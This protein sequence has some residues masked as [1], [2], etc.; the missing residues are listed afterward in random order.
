MILDFSITNPIPSNTKGEKWEQ[1][2]LAF[3]SS[4]LDGSKSIEV[5]TSGSTGNPKKIT[6]NKE[7]MKQ[8]ALATGLFLQ[9]QKRSSALL[10]LPI[11]YIAGKMMLVR[12]EVLGLKLICIKPT[13]KIS[14]DESINF[15]AMTPMQI[16]QSFDSLKFM[17]KVIIGGTALNLET[18]QRL[19]KIQTTQFYETYGMTETVSHI[20]MKNINQKE[21]FFTT[22][23]NISISMDERNCL[24]IDAPLINKE[25][26]ITNDLV[27]IIADNKFVLKGRIDNVINSGGIKIS[28]E[29]IENKLKKLIQQEFV[30][31]SILDNELGEKLVLIIEGKKNE[32]LEIGLK[33]KFS[34]ILTK[35]EKPKEIYFVENFARTNN[36]K[37]VRKEL[38]NN[39]NI[40]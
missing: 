32:E 19:E 31:S 10:C 35:Y 21:D 29:I 30:I 14:T 4:W 9:L 8:S 15:V 3:L 2:I 23:P 39:F 1:D 11:E 6:L 5:Q 34:E 28:P 26:I 17:K 12:A 37:I 18:I 7:A 25:K 13:S 20:A 24:V 27:E 40:A 33:I 38:K 36:G 22:L 16:N